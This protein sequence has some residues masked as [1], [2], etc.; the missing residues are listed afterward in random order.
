MILALKRLS[1]KGM[2]V[3]IHREKEKREKEKTVQ[4]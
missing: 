3:F 2:C 4:L 1:Q